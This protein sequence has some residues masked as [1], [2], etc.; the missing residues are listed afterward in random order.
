MKNEEKGELIECV[1]CHWKGKQGYLIHKFYQ[2]MEEYS[3]PNC[4]N[5]LFYSILEE[6][7]KEK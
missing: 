2:N 1:L 7:H 4:E 5:I 6:M 3:C